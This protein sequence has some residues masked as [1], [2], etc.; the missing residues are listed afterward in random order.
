MDYS[1][2]II[3]PVRQIRLR[4]ELVAAKAVTTMVKIRETA[5]NHSK[6]LIT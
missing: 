2:W 6:K 1:L 3:H 5:I 4:N